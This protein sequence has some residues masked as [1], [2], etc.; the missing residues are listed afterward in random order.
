MII[1]IGIV[2]NMSIRKLKIDTDNEYIP[3][4]IIRYLCSCL[5]EMR[6]L[7]KTNNIFTYKR[8][9]KIMQSL[10]EEIQIHANRMEA[11]L[12]YG[13]DL[14]KLHKLRKKL[15]KQVKELKLKRDELI[16]EDPND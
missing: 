12:E 11:G 3:D 6:K 10:I 8:N 2:S 4:H 9:T 5:D 7:L 14:E 1:L 13:D 16:D 15:T